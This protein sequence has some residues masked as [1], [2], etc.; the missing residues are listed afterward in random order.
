VYER[1]QILIEDAVEARSIAL[2]RQ[3]PG[4]LWNRRAV[5]MMG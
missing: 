2:R 5:D 1:I 3:L 4:R